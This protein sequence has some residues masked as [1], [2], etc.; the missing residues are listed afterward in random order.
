MYNIMRGKGRGGTCNNERGRGGGR[1]RCDNERE[2]GGAIM[3]G[4][5]EE[6]E[7]GRYMYMYNIHV[8]W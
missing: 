7:V 3:R 1:V 2:G 6:E 8:G 5:G 4:K